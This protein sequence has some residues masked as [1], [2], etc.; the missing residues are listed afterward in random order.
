M[1]VCVVRYLLALRTDERYWQTDPCNQWKLQLH[2]QL[3]AF[4]LWPVSSVETR[5]SPMLVA[6]GYAKHWFGLLVQ[7]DVCPRPF[8]D[9]EYHTKYL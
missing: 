8:S 9:Q 3:G 4:D 6:D 7:E 5:N 1:L 2:A